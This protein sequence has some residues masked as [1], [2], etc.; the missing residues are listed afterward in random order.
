MKTNVCDWSAITSDLRRVPVIRIIRSTWH[1][2]KS[3]MTC[4]MAAFKHTVLV[5][6]MHVLPRSSSN[7]DWCISWSSGVWI[8]S[9]LSSSSSF[10]LSVEQVIRDRVL[11]I[12][13]LLEE[14]LLKCTKLV[15]HND[16]LL[17]SSCEI[18]RL[19]YKSLML[20]YLMI[21]SPK[22]G[23][24][25]QCVNWSSLS[26]M[27][28]VNSGAKRHIKIQLQPTAHISVVHYVEVNCRFKHE[29]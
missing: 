1:R 4:W 29:P 8:S 10:S 24:F 3:I 2:A 15:R 19:Y 9:N 21:E 6:S 7:D 13:R 26:L 25:W 12:S 28:S 22:T 5:K 14:A 11:C 17:A 16:P 27:L 20:V 18:K 23:L